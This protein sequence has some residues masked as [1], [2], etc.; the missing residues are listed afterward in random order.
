MSQI[1]FN[2]EELQYG[3]SVS[4]L[5]MSREAYPGEQGDIK[6][7]GKDYVS[8]DVNADEYEANARQGALEGIILEAQDDASFTARV[9]ARTASA[10][11]DPVNMLVTAW[12]VLARNDHD[13]AVAIFAQRPVRKAIRDAADNDFDSFIALAAEFPFILDDKGADAQDLEGVIQIALSEESALDSRV[14]ESRGNEVKQAVTRASLAPW[15]KKQFS[16]KGRNALL[17][18]A[19]SNMA[20][21]VT[22]ID[23][24][25][26]TVR[27]GGYE[28][29]I[30]TRNSVITAA[31]RRR[32]NR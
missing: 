7:F 10:S 5:T 15:M 25:V 29:S 24:E 6:R 31:K 22:S 2:A 13:A 32:S 16:K 12:R 8:F 30:D 11:V 18:A 28:L 3:F 9:I 26:A 19:H 21:N 23:G 27:K 1:T 4:N 20:A 17:A 14:Q